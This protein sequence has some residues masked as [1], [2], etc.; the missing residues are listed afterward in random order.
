MGFATL[1]EEW[2]EPTVPVLCSDSSS[3]LHVVKKRGPGRMEHIAL[4]MLALQEWCELK[5]LRFER[6]HTDE[7][8]S[9]RLTKPMSYD[10]LV[11]L[12]LKIGLSGG[13]YDIE[14]DLSRSAER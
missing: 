14:K 5:R 2:H 8:E 13:I 3:A 11:K 6:L 10:R 1:L 12:S 9:D 4:R 7:N